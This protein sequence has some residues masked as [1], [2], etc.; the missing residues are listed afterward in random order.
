MVTLFTTVTV[1]KWV[2]L[3]DPLLHKY[4]FISRTRRCGYHVYQTERFMVPRWLVQHL[5][6]PHKFERQPFWNGDK[7]IMALSTEFHANLPISSKL[8]SGDTD[9]QHDDLIRLTSCLL[10][11]VC[12]KSTRAAGSEH[13]F[14]TAIHRQPRRYTS[15]QNV[16]KCHFTNTV[17]ET[18]RERERER[19]RRNNIWHNTWKVAKIS[20]VMTIQKLEKWFRMPCTSK[21]RMFWKGCYRL[22]TN[23]KPRLA[24]SQHRRH[25]Y[26]AS[27]V[28][29]LWT[30]KLFTTATCKS[31]T[32]R[33][34]SRRGK[35]IYDTCRPTLGPCLQWAEGMYSY[36]IR[37]WLLQG[38]RDAIVSGSCLVWIQS[39]ACVY[40][41]SRKYWSRQLV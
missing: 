28:T 27:R 38:M 36:E 11:K 35:T 20:I 7:K 19:E 25:I 4:G 17:S 21:V 8:I 10:R 23:G 37:S 16:T 5:H 24:T 33:F 12:K 6:A 9:K 40:Y 13:L 18:E 30:A 3:W 1:V 22:C 29:S 39:T 26:I 14:C 34:N 32:T 41:A 31:W 15:Y 2:Q